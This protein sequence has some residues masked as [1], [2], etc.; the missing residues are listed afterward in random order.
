MLKLL[1]KLVLLTSLCKTLELDKYS[2]TTQL[3][4]HNSGISVYSD[5]RNWVLCGWI[6]NTTKC[7]LWDPTTTLGFNFGLSKFVVGKFAQIPTCQGGSIQ[8]QLWLIQCQLKR[9]LASLLDFG[10]TAI[11]QE[12]YQWGKT[13]IKNHQ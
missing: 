5:E 10:T 2:K 11:L 3:F 8:F 6:P 12:T 9:F 1:K 4:H 7:Q 13:I